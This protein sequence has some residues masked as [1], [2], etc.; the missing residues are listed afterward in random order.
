MDS[1]WSLL[2]HLLNTVIFTLGGIEFGSI[3]ANPNGNWTGRDWGFLF[4]LFVLVN[5]IRLFLLAVAYPCYS[6]IGLGT[7][8]QEMLFSTWAGLRGA[9]GIALA[10][11]LNNTVRA[12]TEDQDLLNLTNKVFGMV[13]GIA[14]LTLTINAPLSKPLLAKLGLIE[15]TEGRK[16]IVKQ[17]E[18]ATRRRMLDDF[19]HLMTDPRFYFVDFAL[20]MHHCSPLRELT[21][22]E[23]ED[24]V[25]MNRASVHPDQY[26]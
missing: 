12:A 11:G 13:G 17:V 3:I 4:L 26:K 14:F 1:F 7:N 2:E 23:L 16:N 6:R 25:E 9:V 5:V 10:L 21:A 22:K 15:S 8:W 19:L 24:G 20:V 18:T